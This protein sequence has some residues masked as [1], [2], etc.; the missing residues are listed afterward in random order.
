[1]TESSL[2]LLE[3]KEEQIETNEKQRRERLFKDYQESQYYKD[4]L[5]NRLKVLDACQRSA[6]AKVY[7]LAACQKDPIF[8]IENFCWTPNDKFEQYH[9]PFIP[10]PFQV[11]TIYW[12][13]EHID[14][15]QDA[16]LEKSREM[17][18][19]WL[20]MTLFLWKWLFN[21]NFNVLVGSYKKE[22]VDDRTKDS[23]FG[24]LDYNLRMLPKW[25]LPKRFNFERHRNQMKLVNPQNYNIIKG[26]TMNP[27]FGRGSRRTCIFMDEGAYW[28]YFQHAWDGCGQ[29][30][31][32]RL[33]ASTPNGY[34]SFAML[35]ES[36]IEV[37][38]LLWSL[39][40]LKD[41]AWYEYEKGRNTDESQAREIDISYQH[42]VKGR[43]YPEWD[44]VEYGLFPYNPDLPLYVGWDFGRT[45]DTAIIWAQP[46]LNGKLA[47]VDCYSNR[48]KLI[49]FYVPF[50]T[51]MINSDVMNKYGY[52]YTD[53][54]LE[55]IDERRNWQRGVHFGDPSG[56]QKNQVTNRTVISALKDNGIMIQYRDE[57]K[58]F[59]NRVDAAKL[60]IRDRLVVNDNSRTKMLKICIINSQYKSLKRGGVEIVDSRN[61]EPK[62]DSNSHM[63]SA[64][65]YLALGLRD[66]KGGRSRVM[67]DKIKQRNGRRTIRY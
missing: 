59:N 47:I 4:K 55:L 30:T 9:F 49:D 6:E 28:E 17:G 20:I 19:T 23:L 66:L 3:K 21:D 58:E 34:N 11:D 7:A 63:R 2:G 41:Q 67:V 56:R 50:I 42:S 44:N 13:N 54:E 52:R 15:G 5:I 45:D 57:W 18:A 10:F 8:F 14:K 26:D 31:N 65:E 60:M 27:E 40:P 48:N 37:L 29:T 61:R 1:M 32:C 64:L 35:R 46:Q 24:M 38:R 36:G 12:L 53:K 16:L 62:H 51:G 25:M 33:T 39:H 22:L 43:V